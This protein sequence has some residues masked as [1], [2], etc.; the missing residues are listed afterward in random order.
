MIR[1]CI[2]DDKKTERDRLKQYAEAFLETH[3][4]FCGTVKTF[5]SGEEMLK[6]VERGG[7]YDIYL[8]D[9][10]TPE[11]DGI[12]LARR[13]REMGGHGEI[14]FLT[15]TREY[16]VEAFEV[17]A[18][19]YLVKPIEKEDFDRELSYCMR[20]LEPKVDP[21]VFLKTRDG[22]RKVYVREIIEVESFNH[23]RVCTL[24]DGTTIETPATL[25]FLREE[26]MKYPD[27]FFPHR[28]YIVNMGYVNS[29]TKAE[30]LM[31]SGKRIPVS[32]RVYPKLREMYMEYVC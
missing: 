3:P 26:L 6:S 4:G 2:C 28:A 23:V 21:S 27:F 17:G 12:G 20:R 16:A 31:E 32:R 10:L 1:I 5:I 8:L 25:S 11:A 14:L 19:G 15:V 30:L 24:T 7:G 9:V 29:V 13:I 18:A 22:V